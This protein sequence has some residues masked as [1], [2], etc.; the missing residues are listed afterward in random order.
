MRYCLLLSQG[1]VE[2]VSWLVKSLGSLHGWIFFWRV[3]PPRVYRTILP[4][5]GDTQTVQILQHDSADIGSMPV[6]ITATPSYQ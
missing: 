4:A 1:E 5:C 3:E 2:C 6:S